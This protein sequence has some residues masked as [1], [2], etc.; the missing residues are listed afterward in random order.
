LCPGIARDLEVDIRTLEGRL[1]EQRHALDEAKRA[2]LADE[3]KYKYQER[4]RQQLQS[5]VAKHVSLQQNI[6]VVTN[7]ASR[8]PL[9]GLARGIGEIARA[10]QAKFGGG[11]GGG[12][13]AKG[14]GG[15]GV[16]KLD[17]LLV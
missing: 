3:I 14:G 15:G 17:M 4:E 13:E 7:K 1:E 9:A 10:V 5:D 8:F 2:M 12:G 6:S 16:Q 11:G